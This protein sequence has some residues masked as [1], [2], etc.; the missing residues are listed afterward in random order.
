MYGPVEPV[1][2]RGYG[3]GGPVVALVLLIELLAAL[4]KSVKNAFPWPTISSTVGEL[5]KRWDWVGVVVGLIAVGLFQ[6]I[7]YRDQRRE[8]GRAYRRA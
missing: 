7:A 4:S 8:T 1:E 6:A 5:E 2:R 3:F